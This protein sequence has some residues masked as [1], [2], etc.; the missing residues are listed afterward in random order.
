M[1]ESRVLRT[2]QG[3]TRKSMEKIAS[4]A[5]KMNVLISPDD[6]GSPKV[7]TAPITAILFALIRSP[8]GAEEHNV[9]RVS[10]AGIPRTSQRKS[11]G[12]DDTT[13]GQN[14]TRCHMPHTEIAVHLSV[15]EVLFVIRGAQRNIFF[16]IHSTEYPYTIF[17]EI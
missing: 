9:H 7:E 13:Y 16:V 17:H 8:A 10:F 4:R 11:Y 15:S 1:D 14:F 5:D 3:D 2:F 6:L 12:H